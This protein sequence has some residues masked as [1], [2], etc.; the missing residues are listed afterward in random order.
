MAVGDPVT[1][2]AHQASVD[3]QRGAETDLFSNVSEDADDHEDR[4]GD[5]QT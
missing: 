4:R 2:N 1:I 3:H 5:P